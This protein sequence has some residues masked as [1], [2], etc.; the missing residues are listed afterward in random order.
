MPTVSVGVLVLLDD[1]VL[2]EQHTSKL[3]MKGMSK[4]DFMQ[5][6]Q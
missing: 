3:A 5:A 6:F 1:D 2:L 4:W